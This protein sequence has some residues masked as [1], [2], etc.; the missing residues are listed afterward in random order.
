MLKRTIAI[1]IIALVFWSGRTPTTYSSGNCKSYLD[2][3]F[4]YDLN[5]PNYMVARTD[6][7]IIEVIND[8][9]KCMVKYKVQ[10]AKNGCDHDLIYE[11]TTPSG[12][13]SPM[14]KGDV[15]HIKIIQATSKVVSYKATYKDVEQEMKMY[16]IQ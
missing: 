12:V 14:K 6:T 10:W 1:T 7:S 15:I 5:N 13:V 9:R 8:E 11:R 4:V 16:R 2:G 3:V